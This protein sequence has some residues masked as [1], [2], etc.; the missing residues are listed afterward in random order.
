MVCCFGSACLCVRVGKTYG[1]VGLK[2]ISDWFYY[3]MVFNIIMLVYTDNS[4]LVSSLAM[5]ILI[6]AVGHSVFFSLDNQM[7]EG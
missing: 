4:W 5:L 3:G 7:E 2:K 6:F 1:A